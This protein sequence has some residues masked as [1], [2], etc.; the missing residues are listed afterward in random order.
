LKFFDSG[1]FGS[2]FFTCLG[3]SGV[4][5][6]WYD[7]PRRGTLRIIHCTVSPSTIAVTT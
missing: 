1:F 7:V 3:L 4:S 5:S 6:R 2:Q